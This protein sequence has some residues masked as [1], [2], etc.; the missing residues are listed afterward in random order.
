MTVIEIDD[1]ELRLVKWNLMP[2]N[3]NYREIYCTP[4]TLS[5]CEQQFVA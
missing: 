1:D 3:G 2:R 5:E 4:M